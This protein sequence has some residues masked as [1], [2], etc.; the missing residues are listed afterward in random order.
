MDAH[1]LV[2]KPPEP[3]GS[4]ILRNSP[5]CDWECYCWVEYLGLLLILGV[6]Q[7]YS[8]SN[9]GNPIEECH[10]TSIF[11]AIVV[12]GILAILAGH[13]VRFGVM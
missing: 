10:P 6:C 4:P 9:P 7:W 2:L 3:W 11:L 5:F 1:D 8:G 13:D 12:R